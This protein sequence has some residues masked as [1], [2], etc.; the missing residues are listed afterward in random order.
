MRTCDIFQQWL[1]GTTWQSG[2]LD[3]AP[4]LVRSLFTPI[5]MIIMQV[6]RMNNGR[7]QLLMF[8]TMCASE[9]F[10]HQRSTVDLPDERGRFSRLFAQSNSL[11]VLTSQYFKHYSTFLP[12][13]YTLPM[14]IKRSFINLSTPVTLELL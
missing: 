11:E 12:S 7:N 8:M 14:N 1:L 9:A 2:C 4:P 3:K 13:S 6:T 5:P 10:H